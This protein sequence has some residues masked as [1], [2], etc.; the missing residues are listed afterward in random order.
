MQRL[1]VS[2]KLLFMWSKID[3]K[4]TVNFEWKNGSHRDKYNKV[5][6]NRLLYVDQI[7]MLILT[8]IVTVH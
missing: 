5:E 2:V 6:T 7:I 4:V 1:F 8:V 3:S